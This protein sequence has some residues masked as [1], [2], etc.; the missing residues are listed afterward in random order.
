MTGGVADAIKDGK[1]GFLINPDNRE[2]LFSKIDL[3]F[4]DTNLRNKMGFNGY[5][6]SQRAE[7]RKPHW[8]DRYSAHVPIPGIPNTVS[9]S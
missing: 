9:S 1:T 3:L 6:N 2:E 8:E 7:T 4:S 5:N